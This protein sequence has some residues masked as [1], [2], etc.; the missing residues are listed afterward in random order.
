MPRRIV[1]CKSL[2]CMSFWCL[3]WA[4]GLLAQD[5]GEMPAFKEMVNFCKNTLEEIARLDEAE[6]FSARQ[7][8][9]PKGDDGSLQER[10]HK[11]YN[12]E[13]A[14]LL[15]VAGDSM[16][17]LQ[18]GGERWHEVR[19]VKYL[20][21]LGLFEKARDELRKLENRDRRFQNIYHQHMAFL[22]RW[23]GNEKEYEN[24]REQAKKSMDPGPKGRGGKHPF[25]YAEEVKQM[26]EQKYMNWVRFSSKLDY[27]RG[28]VKSKPD[29][30]EAWKQLGDHANQ[31]GY[32]HD[33]IVA[34]RV[35]YEVFNIK[36]EVA[37]K[38]AKAYRETDQPDKFKTIGKK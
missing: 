11:I 31:L 8:Q 23:L 18:D 4:G 32:R 37:G 28:R 1:F 25:P 27:Y 30:L 13:L 34:W 10:I 16:P 19:H 20:V 26:Y 15:K 2:I 22:E 36:G 21:Q 7:S 5:T 17:K 24:H 6:K 3:S 14:D 38:L 12:E 35:L 9:I 29:D 33:E